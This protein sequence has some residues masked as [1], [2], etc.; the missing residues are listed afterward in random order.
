MKLDEQQQLREINQQY[1][2][3]KRYLDPIHEK[4]NTFEELYRCFIDSQSYPHNARVFDPR[5]FRVIETITPRMVSSEPTGSFYPSEEGDIAT[6]QILNSL[7]KYDWNRAVM[8]PKLVTFVKSLLL[9]GTAFGRTY[10]D[11]RECDK[12]QMQPKRLNGKMVWTPKNTKKVPVTEYDGPNFETLNI[13][14][15]F[16]DPNA[17]GIENM[18][19]FIYRTFKTIDELENENDARGGEYW[20][21]LPE[22]KNLV[23][24]GFKKGDYQPRGYQPS[25]INYREHRRVM[26][27]T[28]ELHGEDRSN[29]EFV[30]LIRYTRDRWLFTVPEYGLVIRDV[31]NPY[32]HGELPIIYGVDYPYPGE[33]YGM[34]EIEPIDRIQ[35]AINGVLNQRLDNVQLTLNTM[36]KVKKQSGVDIHT[37]FSAPGNIVFTDDMDAVDSIQVPDVTGSTFVQTMNYLTGAMQNGSGITDYTVGLDTGANTKNETATGVRLI[38]QEANA[39]FKLKIQLFNHMVIERVANQWKD[40]RIQ[41]T[42][43]QQ[44]IRIIG[45]NEVKYMK[46]K[47]EMATTDM[48]GQPI[49][50]GDL[51]TQGKLVVGK[52]DN[53][54]FLTLLPED[55][56]PSIVGNYDFIASVDSEQLT[57]PIALQENFFVA[58]DKVKD[59]V[60]VQGLA[61]SGKKLNYAALTEKVF[62][63]LHL[64]IEMNDILEDNQPAP[65]G[66]DQMMDQPDPM[67]AQMPQ[68][69]Q[70]NPEAEIQSFMEGAQNGQPEGSPAPIPGGQPQAGIGL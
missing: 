39:Q 50:P 13:Y 45:R 27:S 11:Y 20:K 61:A 25:D 24:N 44:K 63:K 68:M 23:M 62:E 35:R 43:E 7:M 55:I 16:P 33:L 60:W 54:A 26:L 40:L 53:F 48:M 51:E 28:Q 22:L 67:M 14:D 42:T 12:E 4:M 36:W 37:L 29:P 66:P 56:Q 69:P 38:Q 47:T 41:Y 46:E 2:L 70:G 5:I 21:N 31:Q 49:I 15:C 17:T 59:P 58:L 64:G 9:F 19:W 52:D 30:V 34:G 10:W 18:R 3:A 65:V 8:F 32:F 6:T 1:E 57:D